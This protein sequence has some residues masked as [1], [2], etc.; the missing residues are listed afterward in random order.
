MAAYIFSNDKAEQQ[1]VF[2]EIPAGAAVANHVAVHVLVP[3]LPFGGV[4]ASGSGA[5]HGKWGY[6]QFSHRK[7]TLVMRTRPDLKM[8]YPPYSALSKKVLRKL[9]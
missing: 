7:A 4:G 6:E 5:Y 8:V 1:R 3:Q 9:M 2:T